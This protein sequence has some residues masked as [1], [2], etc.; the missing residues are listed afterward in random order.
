MV[1]R[2]L[3]LAGIVAAALLAAT[4]LGPSLRGVAHPLVPQGPDGTYQCSTCHG[5]G[6]D[7]SAIPAGTTVP[8]PPPDHAAYKPDSCVTC[9]ATVVA[10]DPTTPS[11]ALCATCHGQ[12]DK[13]TKLPDGETLQVSVDVAAFRS[14]VHGDFS[15]TECHPK[16][17]T[18]PHAP[19]TAA[20]LR[21]FKQEM[22]NVCQSCHAEATASYAESFHG[23]AARLGVS[24]AAT[25]TDCHTAH[26]VKAPAQWTLAERATQCATCHT[27]AT[28]SF[29]SGWMGHREPSLGWFPMVFF[30]SKFFVALTALTL[31][32]GIVHVELDVLRWSS[33]KIRGRKEEVD[34]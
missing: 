16:Q 33:N 31:G 4:L 9:H 3:F 10:Q 7:P 14:S 12:K 29:A 8:L 2:L 26:A 28:A 27:G 34:Q 18:I 24:R 15:C 20:D 23:M 13:L 11:Y 21:A 1:R 22:G 32:V 6:A 30:A 19:L 5:P 17:R 25:C